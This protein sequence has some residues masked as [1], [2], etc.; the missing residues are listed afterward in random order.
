M[1][2]NIEYAK[3]VGRK[4]GGSIWRVFFESVMIRLDLRFIAVLISVDFRSTVV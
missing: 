4:K 1:F 2:Y 3:S